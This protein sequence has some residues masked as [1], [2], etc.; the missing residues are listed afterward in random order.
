MGTH[1]NKTGTPVSADPN[2]LVLKFVKG[3]CKIHNY[4]FYSVCYWY[5]ILSGVA[6]AMPYRAFYRMPGHI[7]RNSI[8]CSHYILFH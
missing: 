5:I 1:V 2:I 6:N 3:S 4:Q 8:E 7:S